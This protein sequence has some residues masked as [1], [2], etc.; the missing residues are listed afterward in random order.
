MYNPWSNYTS[1]S[2]VDQRRD[3][4][5]SDPIPS[6]DRM[7]QGIEGAQKEAE[8]VAMRCIEMLNNLQPHHITKALGKINEHFLEASHS[9]HD[10]TIS[11]M[12]KADEIRIKLR[13]TLLVS[14]GA[15][16]QQGTVKESPKISEAFGP[17][18]PF[19]P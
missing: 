16:P 2:T 14:V 9:Y 13:E 6:Q 15:G 10:W 1:T 3:A 7:V 18:G 8:E 19:V 4:V 17:G 12:K 11:E 5:G